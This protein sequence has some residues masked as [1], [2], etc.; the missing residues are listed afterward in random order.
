MILTDAQQDILA[1]LIFAN[2]TFKP[3]MQEAARAGKALTAE[4]TAVENFKRDRL[5]RACVEAGIPKRQVGISG[6]GSSS[7]SAILESLARTSLT[8]VLSPTMALVAAN[9]RSGQHD[10]FGPD[11]ERFTPNLAD[12]T[13]FSV[14]LFDRD[15]ST[16]CKAAGWAVG[17]ATANGLNM[18]VFSVSK[19][20]NGNVFV[21]AVTTDFMPEHGLR[22]PVVQWSRIAENAAECLVWALANGFSA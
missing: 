22:H 9:A 5:I 10:P 8:P 19:A 18:A 17:D 2:E 4:L 7:P 16:A 13:Q 3:A 15:L 21:S 11:P 12:P 14:E 6:L 1:D 20:P